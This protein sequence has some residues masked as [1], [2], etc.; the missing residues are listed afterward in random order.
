MRHSWATVSSAILFLA[1]VEEYLHGEVI[2]GS[3]NSFHY[4]LEPS[5]AHDETSPATFEAT[6][7]ST[8]SPNDP[9]SLAVAHR[10]YLHGLVYSLLLNDAPFTKSL[11][12][13]MNRLDYIVLQITSLSELQQTLLLQETSSALCDS[14]DQM[15]EESQ[16]IKGLAEVSASINDNF[17]VLINRLREVELQHIGGEYLPRSDRPSEEDSFVPWNGRGSISRLLTKLEGIRVS[18]GRG[19]R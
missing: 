16:I 1:E 4:W 11:R 7:T 2:A 8:S 9:E 5:R 12:A 19:C 14:T 15:K 6:D 17:H 13:A 18:Q 10:R 3:W